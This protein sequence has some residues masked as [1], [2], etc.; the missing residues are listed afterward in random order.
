M[1]TGDAPFFKQMADFYA[2]SDNYHQPMMGGPAPISA[3]ATGDV[4]FYNLSGP[5]ATPP[6]SFIYQ[7]V[8]TSQVED[9]DPQPAGSNTNWYTEDG[10]RGGSYVNCSIR[11]QAEPDPYPSKE[12][13][14]QA[15]LRGG[16]LLPR[17][18]LQPRLQ[19]RWHARQPHQ[20]PDPVHAAAP[21]SE[22]ADHRRR[23]LSQKR[24]VEMVFRR[25]AMAQAPT[26]DYCGI[27]D[28]LTGFTSIMTTSLASNLQDVNN[29]YADIAAGRFPPSRSSARSS[30]WLAIRPTP[31]LR[32]MRTL[33]PTWSTWS[34]IRPDLWNKTAILITADEGGGYYGDPGYIQTVDFLATARGSR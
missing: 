3:L 28:P 34:T 29:L 19:G 27:C 8:V 17:Q 2:I 26:A 14:R 21:A 20:R 1:N 16:H 24:N 25:S 4:A 9:P 6:T 31:R 23:A 32:S 11:S 30:R 33:L 22:P 7:G 10:Y 18:Q 5:P 12:P 15:Q 13:E